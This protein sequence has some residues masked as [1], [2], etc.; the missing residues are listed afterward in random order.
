MNTLSIQNNQIHQL[1]SIDPT[2]EVKRDLSVEFQRAWEDLDVDQI[3]N[4]LNQGASPDQQVELNTRLSFNL[5]RTYIESV[6]DRD[7]FIP[8]IFTLSLAD[9]QSIT[10]DEEV[11][12]KVMN[13][14]DSFNAN[15]DSVTDHEIIYV[16]TTL[17]NAANF[18]S[19]GPDYPKI[20]VMAL[21]LTLQNLDLMEALVQ[22]GFDFSDL[23]AL[24]ALVGHNYTVDL[25]DPES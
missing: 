7:E 15:P 8:E 19:I 2:L 1:I 12:E 14:V 25:I 4:I 24:E 6:F 18:G 23:K 16:A 13:I 20:S 10:N 22:A 3:K 21:A 11:I 9:L 5:L 17:A